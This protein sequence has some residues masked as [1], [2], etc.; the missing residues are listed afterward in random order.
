M[1]KRVLEHKLSSTDNLKAK[2]HIRK[3]Q[4]QALILAE[5]PCGST[6]E[7]KQIFSP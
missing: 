7:V 1:K 3:P 4:I 6:F 5:I 2:M